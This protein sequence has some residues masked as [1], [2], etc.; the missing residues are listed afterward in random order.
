MKP[1][2]KFMQ[3]FSVCRIVGNGELFRFTSKICTVLHNVGVGL[4]NDVL[5]MYFFAKTRNPLGCTVISLFFTVLS[6]L[7][8]WRGGLSTEGS[9]EISTAI[10]IE[11][12]FI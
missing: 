5:K 12:Y 11:H 7:R 3:Y 1:P 8:K 9:V 6:V 4:G 10:L 2:S